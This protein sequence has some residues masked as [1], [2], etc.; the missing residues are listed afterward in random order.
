MLR[1]R[2]IVVLK[3]GRPATKDWISAFAGTIV[4]LKPERPAQDPQSDWIL[5]HFVPQDDEVL[6]PERPA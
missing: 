6:K 2:A 3:P 1:F 5:R 4:V